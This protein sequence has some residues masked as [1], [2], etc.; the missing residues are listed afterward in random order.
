MNKRADTATQPIFG[1]LST[2][3]W[4]LT[5]PGRLYVLGPPGF[6]RVGQWDKCSLRQYYFADFT[7]KLFATTLT[8]QCKPEPAS[9]T[10]PRNLSPAIPIS[11]SSFYFCFDILL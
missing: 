1:L 4:W 10:S 8:I 6:G 5:I 11:P 7:A 3:S 2:E 9:P